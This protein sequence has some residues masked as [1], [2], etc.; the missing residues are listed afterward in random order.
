MASSLSNAASAVCKN[1]ESLSGQVLVLRG[2]GLVKVIGRRIS[3]TVLPRIPAFKRLFQHLARSRILRRLAAAG[4]IGL[5]LASPTKRMPFRDLMPSLVRG[6]SRGPTPLSPTVRSKVRPVARRG[7][8]PRWSIRLTHLALT[9]SAV[10]M[11]SQLR[12]LVSS[13][14]A[15]RR[16]VRS[17]ASSRATGG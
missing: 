8:H 13:L 9:L 11:N 3:L 1:E 7:Q 16:P 12:V 17:P 15:H 14:E 4:A 5:F 6:R 2:R 10:L